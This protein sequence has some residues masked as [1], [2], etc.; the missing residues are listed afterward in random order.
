M[1]ILSETPGT[2][3]EAFEALQDVVG[4]GTFSRDEAIE[5]LCNVLGIDEQQASRAFDGL[6]AS[7]SVEEE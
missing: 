7:G 2:R 3:N 5:I 4:Q 6:V 1:Y